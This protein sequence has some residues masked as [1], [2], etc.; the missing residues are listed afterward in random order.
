MRNSDS[1]LARLL[2]SNGPASDR[3]EKMSL[4][5]F[6]IGDWT[7]DAVMHTPDGKT[8]ERQG[9][10]SFAWVLEGRAIQ[11]VW[12]LPDFFYGSTLRVYDPGI[13]AWHIF[14]SD[15][16]MQYHGR[17]IGRKQGND[18]VQLGK[19]DDGTDTRWS[20]TNIA[21]NSFRWVGEFS[22]DGGTTWQLLAEFE[23]Q[24]RA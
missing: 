8:H 9:K 23:C 10:I 20:F 4:Y 16:L 21:A 15:P 1:S 5:G 12:A 14:W 11:D 17:Q 24:R 3:A 13:D 7:M 18:I 2:F 19:A 22:T 6:L